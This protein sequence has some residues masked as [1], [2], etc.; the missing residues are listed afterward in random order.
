MK[1]YTLSHW[2]ALEI[3]ESPYRNG[4]FCEPATPA[5]LIKTVGVL[6]TKPTF[7]NHYLT[8]E[9]TYRGAFEWS[10]RQFNKWIKLLN[11]KIV[12]GY[13]DAKLRAFFKDH[14]S[15]PAYCQSVDTKGKEPK[16]PIPQWLKV[17][18]QTKL[19]L[20]NE[21][22]WTYEMSQLQWD[23]DTIYEMETGES[24]IESDRDREGIE[25]MK[26]QEAINPA[27]QEARK[28]AEIL[29]ADFEARKARGE[30]RPGEEWDDAPLPIAIKEEEVDFNI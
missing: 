1:R 27:W 19:F 15:P 4:E 5:D 10:P 20:T 18:L 29:K 6:S 17:K 22:A 30:T 28:A 8:P 12:F 23:M 3:L 25:W 26:Q 2:A 24:R 9:M 7:W 16:V 14:Y 21:E 13:Y 11:N